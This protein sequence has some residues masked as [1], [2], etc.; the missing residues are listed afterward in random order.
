MGHIDK[1]RSRQFSASVQ[2]MVDD[3]IVFDTVISGM[4]V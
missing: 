2:G 3:K 1:V 4:R